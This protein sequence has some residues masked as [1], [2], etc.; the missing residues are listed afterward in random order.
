MT[1]PPSQTQDLGQESTSVMD[2]LKP[3]TDASHSNEKRRRVLVC[4]GRDFTN[5]DLMVRILDAANAAHPF[6]CVIYGMARGADDIAKTWAASRG[7][8]RLGFPANWERHGRAAGAIRNQQ[9][10]DKGRPDL[11]IAFPG[12]RGTADMVRRAREA[13]IP[14]TLIGA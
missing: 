9:M 12:G 6:M 13:N 14:V 8:A 10:L 11:V 2:D 5:A 1:S 3:T 7:I 4:G